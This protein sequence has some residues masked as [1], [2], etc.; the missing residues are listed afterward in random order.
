VSTGLYALRALPSVPENP[1]LIFPALAEQAL[2]TGIKA[3]F[4]CGLLGTIVSA[5][6]GYSLVAGAS[7]GREIVARVKPME[8]AKIK[9]AVQSG[10]A[11]SGVLALILA[12]SFQSVVA[13]WYSWAG[14]V[15]GALLIPTLAAYRA[16][17]LVSSPWRSQTVNLA[18]LASFAV[19]FAW[20]LYGLRT[21]N[22]F[23][24]VTLAGQEFSLGTLVPGL[25][26]SMIVLGYESISM[27][28][29]RER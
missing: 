2:P 15:V 17:N 28:N 22:P 11:V 24:T 27:R 19:S 16:T 25:L 26:V 1:L 21:N 3:I 18:I 23:L 14:A 13:L 4:L 12:M 6:V 10:I 29:R 9:G 5:M 8:E 20:M 7:L